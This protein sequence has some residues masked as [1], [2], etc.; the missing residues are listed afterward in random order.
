MS[1]LAAVDDSNP[2]RIKYI[3]VLPE[4]VPTTPNG[5]QPE[6]TILGL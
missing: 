1:N 6:F 2:A 4:Y 3:T 5:V